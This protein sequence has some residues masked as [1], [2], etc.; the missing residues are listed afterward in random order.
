MNGAD[1]EPAPCVCG[2]ASPGR[3][4]F[5]VPHHEAPEGRAFVMQC[6]CGLR[7]LDPRPTAATVSRYYAEASGYHAYIGRYR[8]PLKQALWDALRDS[9]AAPAIQPLWVRLARP[10]LR[11]LARWQFDVNVRLDGRRLRVLDV[12]S[13]FGDVLIYLQSRGCRTLGIDLSPDA[14]ERA[15]QYGVDVRTGTMQSLQLT[16]GDFDVVIMSHSLEH[17]PNPAEEIAEAW[18]LLA[19]GG[20]LLLAVPNGD[21]VRLR[22][23]G[24]H[25]SCLMAPFHFWFFDAASLRSMIERQGFHVD[26]VRT[27]TRHYALV[28]WILGCR[29]GYGVAA[30]RSFL[31]YLSALP[32]GARDGDILRIEATRLK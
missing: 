29:R 10:L 32:F 28:E 20:K 9:E 6:D 17:V 26:S 8:S 13:G 31:R 16:P 11:P 2:L 7:R 1:W 21:A 19:P 25:W 14:A 30:T 24:A 18:R 3:P 27:T 4:L 15:R 5:A 23:D 22:V 12:G